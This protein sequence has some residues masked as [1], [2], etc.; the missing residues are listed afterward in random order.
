MKFKKAYVLT[1]K[2]H[3][4]NQQLLALA[5][6]FPGDYEVVPVSCELRSRAKLLY[7]I[8]KLFIRLQKKSAFPIWIKTFINNILLDKAVKVISEG[9]LIFAKTA[10]FEVP[11]LLLSASKN[12]KKI[13]VG[14]P[15]RVQRSYFDL[16]IGTPSTPVDRPDIFLEILPSKSTYREFE[17]HRQKSSDKKIWSLFLGGNAT[18]YHYDVV[19][20]AELLDAMAALTNRYN[21]VWNISTSPRTGLEIENMMDEKL[22]SMTAVINSVNLWSKGGQARVVDY[23]SVSDVIFVSEDSASMLSDAIN[24][25]L[26]LV[27][28]RPHKSCGYNSL[29]TPFF[30]YHENKKRLKRFT[31]SELQSMDLNIAL[32]N[33]FQPVEK[34]WVD[35][36][37]SQLQKNNYL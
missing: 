3:G 9:D 21:I 37:N 1:S 6:N 36:L 18:G 22:R 33:D 13:Y 28:L 16:I 2:H 5:T 27:S 32:L 34:C 10:P 25:R 15:V 23:L 19:L 11:L 12:I 24:S 31:I 29:V 14:E 7:C 4:S 17:A 26:P 35:D 30:Q 8:Y 20:I